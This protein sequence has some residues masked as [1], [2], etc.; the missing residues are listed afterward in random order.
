MNILI[1]NRKS[2][3][4]SSIVYVRVP[5]GF[6][7]V[8]IC[9]NCRVME[10]HFTHNG[11]NRTF[12][13][14]LLAQATTSHESCGKLCCPTCPSWRPSFAR[15]PSSCPETWGQRTTGNARFAKGHVCNAWAK[16]THTW[17]LAMIVM[18]ETAPACSCW[19]FYNILQPNSKCQRGTIAIAVPDGR[20]ALF[21]GPQESFRSRCHTLA[22]GDV[23]LLATATW[24]VEDGWGWYFAGPGSSMKLTR[25]AGK[26]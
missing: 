10:H 16:E 7:C 18:F 19:G 26:R 21:N 13:N 5:I 20:C 11:F 3:W 24:N 22:S 2:R 12:S 14:V 23:R 9:C 25:Y 8:V 17:I 1:Q 15:W 6:N 4:T